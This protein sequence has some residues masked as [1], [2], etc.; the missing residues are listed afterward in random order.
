VSG[1]GPVPSACIGVGIPTV[2][3]AALVA[4][5]VAGEV[6]PAGFPEFYRAHA[7]R[8]YKALAVT[9]GNDDLAQEA[10]NEAMTRAYAHWQRVSRLDNPAG[11]VFR[12]AFNWATSWW[13][14]VRREQGVLTDARHPRVEPTDP[15]V[16]AARDALKEL[17]LAQ[18]TV[19]VCR[20]LLDM[21]TAETAAALRISEGTVKSRLSRGLAA[22]RVAL[23]GKGE[24]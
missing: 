7:A 21:S 18:R 15:A 9:L 17:A 22:L 19:V 16:L 5:P 10:V 14:K 13:R 2:A 6:R 11:W 23:D 8:V 24:R 12:V 20:V 1:T 3:Q 4:E